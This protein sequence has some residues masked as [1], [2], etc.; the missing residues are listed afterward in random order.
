M[1]R[2]KRMATISG[3]VVL[4][5]LVAGFILAGIFGFLLD[6]L[7]IFL[8]I[9][10]A[11]SLISTGFLIYAILML[12]QSITTVRN[13]LKP[14][15]ASVQ[16]TVGIVKD[17]AKTAGQTATTIGSTAQLTKEFAVGPSVRAAA[18]VLAGQ[19][20]VRVFVG[21]GK[22]KSRYEQRRKQQREAMD[23]AAAAGG[24]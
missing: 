2:A 23:A 11:L 10:A 6:V 16:E 7:Y 8:I 21:K 3:I 15:I 12:I 9:L 14:L 20:M 4:I 18:T 17:T 22:T 1:Q 5:L 19:Q 13:E 24:Q